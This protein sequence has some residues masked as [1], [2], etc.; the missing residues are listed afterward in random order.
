MMAHQAARMARM[1]DPGNGFRQAVG[2]IDDARDVDQF[3]VASLFPV[4]NREALNIDMARTR[5]GSTSVDHLDG[6]LVV[7]KNRGRADLGKTKFTKHGTQMFRNLDGF[8]SG[9]KFGLSAGSSSD[10][11]SVATTGNDA[12]GKKE[13][14]ASS[15]VAV[16]KILGMGRI[17]E[18]TELKGRR[19]RRK[20]RKLMLGFGKSEWDMRQ[21]EIGSR[22]PTDDS[23]INGIPKTLGNALQTLAVNLG[24]GS[25]ELGESGNR[26]AN[27]GTGGDMSTEEFAEQGAAGETHPFGKFGMFGC[28]SGK[29]G[30]SVHSLHSLHSVVVGNPQQAQGPCHQGWVV[31]G[32]RGGPFR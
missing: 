32:A 8:D 22:A 13:T 28:V 7:F 11:L 15:R 17:D 14:T 29:S 27:V 24:R 23:P 18:T 3:N 10:G 25:G 16:A 2:G 5:G 4:L 19:A 20:P 1:E 9:K 12:T 6:G 31:Q 21:R 30:G 26:M